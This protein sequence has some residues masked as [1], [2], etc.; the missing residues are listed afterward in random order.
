M[1]LMHMKIRT[2]L[3][4]ASFF[5][6]LML[7]YLCTGAN[8]QP[9]EA[10]IFS[11]PYHYQI[12]S[13]YCGPAALEMLFDFYGAD[14]PQTQI[15]DVART[16][17]D[18][19]YTPDMVRAAHFSNLSTSV[20]KEMP[21][22]ITGYTARKL[23]YAAFEYGGMT[24]DEL[25]SLIAAGYP[26]IVLTYW[27][28]R[29]AVGYNNTHITFQDSYWG[30]M[31]N[32][33]Y[34][35][36][37]L[38]WDYSGH[39]GLFVGPWNV[40]VSNPRN[41]LPGDIFNVTATITYPSPSPFPRDRYPASVA[42]ATVTL[43]TGLTLVS[44]EA[45]KKTIGAGDLT[46]GKSINVTWT[47][48]ADSV[49]HYAISVEA[50][51]KVA[52]FEPYSYE[53]RIGGFGQNIV[54]VTTSLDE[55]PPSTLDDFDGLWQ[56][57][58]FTINLTATDEVDGSGVM[59]TYYKI[60]D[61]SLRTLNSDG[62]PL[63]NFES[64][65]GR[66]EYWS[67]DWAGN[68][69]NHHM[70]TGIKLDK[71]PPHAKA[72]SDQTIAEDTVTFFN[73]TA[74]RDNLGIASHTWTF[75]DGE[76]QTL[77]GVQPNYTFANP[78]VYI[79]E[80][81]VADTAGNYAVDTFRITV[82]D[83]TTPVAEAGPNQT[84]NED[85]LVTLNSSGSEDN[86]G[87]VSYVWTFTDQFITQTLTGPRPTYTFERPGEYVIT[88]Q[89][90]DAAGKWAKDKVVINVLDVTNPVADAGQNVT[91]STGDATVFDAS[92]SSDNVGITSYEWD[93]GDG[94]KSAEA[95]TKHSYMFPGTYTVKLIVTDARGNT[96]VDSITVTVVM[97][98]TFTLIIV[99][100]IAAVGTTVAALFLWKRRK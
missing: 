15:A 93:F 51:G 44:G 25:K 18:G 62:Q 86:V 88:L 26:I 31:Y 2:S 27:H 36:F 78:G 47:V 70:I 83:V 21:E 19:T 9:S 68:E 67:E 64:A 34:A 45:A 94:A 50:E 90:S 23:G 54:A 57:K 41:V 29:V 17:R 16:A 7:M 59:D 58:D 91:V 40:E 52:G 46:A 32:M 3:S 69:E 8:A 39:W 10:Y 75:T 92:G 100:A 95:M 72:G 73:G 42:N 74:S 37:D 84:V 43:P 61:G 80:L 33:T 99:G 81:K 89:V 97:S 13:Y 20:G 28:F 6:F 38:D 71:T 35:A 56:N 1:M 79:V 60:N 30:E 55:T 12:K 14:I 63:I 48:R 66:L 85:T 76:P 77:M 53:D 22:N 11:V 24:L 4:F 96:A 5:L 65:N 49:G 82:V 98:T 87:I